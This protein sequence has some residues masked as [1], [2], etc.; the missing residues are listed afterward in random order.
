MD[1][2]VIGEAVL[3]PAQRHRLWSNGERSGGGPRQHIV[4]VGQARRRGGI[5]ACVPPAASHR[6]RT[7]VP[8]N[9]VIHRRRGGLGL[10]VVGQ[11]R[12]RPG[13]RR[14][15]RGDVHRRRSRQYAFRFD[16]IID[17][18][19]ARVFPRRTLAEVIRAAGRTVGHAAG[20]RCD[21]DAV[22]LA[23]IFPLVTL[24]SIGAG[25][26][27]GGGHVPPGHRKAPL[28]AAQRLHIQP[29]APEAHPDP[30]RRVARVGLQRQRDSLAGIRH[31]GIGGQGAV[32]RRYG[33]G[34]ALAIIL[35]G[36][37]SPC[38]G[39]GGQRVGV[40]GVFE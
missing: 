15:P 19:G 6:D 11:V 10:A 30:I 1:A 35:S 25:R 16:A 21:G 17:R 24:D 37:A 20:G 29:A 38:G 26:A 39:E 2:A 22:G 28:A 9:Q 14:R 31:L 7:A 33:H 12:V 27:R 18:V 40:I 13:Q 4:A 32:L 3:R 36:Q 23:V 8:G 34:V 5:A